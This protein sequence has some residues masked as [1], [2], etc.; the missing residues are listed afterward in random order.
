ME[1]YVKYL[2]NDEILHSA[3]VELI[4]DNFIY[5]PFVTG[6]KLKFSREVYD[7][8][9]HYIKLLTSLIKEFNP[10]DKNQLKLYDDI[11]LSFLFN[12]I[13]KS[14]CDYDNLKNNIKDNIYKLCNLELINNLDKNIEALLCDYIELF[15][16]NIVIYNQHECSYNICVKIIRATLSQMVELIYSKNEYIETI[17]NELQTF[18]CL[19]GKRNTNVDTV[20]RLNADILKEHSEFM[21]DVEITQFVRTSSQSL[22]SLFKDTSV[23]GNTSLQQKSDKENREPSLILPD[24]YDLLNADSKVCSNSELNEILN[25]AEKIFFSEP[26][27]QPQPQQHRKSVQSIMNM[28]TSKFQCV[29]VQNKSPLHSLCSSYTTDTLDALDTSDIA[30]KQQ[31]NE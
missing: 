4:I 18:I 23:D 5:D 15:Y 10:H 14:D 16:K 22:Q 11:T 12:L 27:P 24:S 19:C 9:K 31:N 29:N 28:L 20:T 3:N 7:N 2:L 6:N 30:T 21:G 25:S 17:K 8:C 13:N 1:V 26:Q